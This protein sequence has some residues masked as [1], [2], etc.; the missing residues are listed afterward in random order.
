VAHC[1]ASA[2]RP[3]FEIADIVRAHRAELEKQYRLTL[4]QRRVLSAIELCRTAAL[5]GHLDVCRRCGFEQPAYNSCRNRHCPKCQALA[6]EKWIAARSE[7]VL[8]VGHFHVVFTLPSELRPLTRAFPKL[9]FEALFCAASETLLDLGQTRLGGVLGVTMVLHTW[10]RDLRF[11]PH[12]HAI[13]SAGVL[14]RAGVWQATSIK[15]LFPVEVLA[16]VFRGKMLDFLHRRHARLLFQ[17]YDPF[18]DPE[19]FDRLTARLAH[20]RWCVYAKRPFRRA[21][22]LLGY[23]GRYTHRVAIANSRLVELRPDAV[24]FRT[25]NGKTETL[26]PVQFLRRFVEHVLP[27]GFKKI[28]HFG[29]YATSHA[30]TLE[31]ARCQLSRPTSCATPASSWSERLLLLTGHDATHCP[32]CGDMLEHRPL[33]EHSARAPPQVTP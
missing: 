8:P 25:K 14:D 13:V 30:D 5:G 6:Q 27:A 11:H 15:Y 23:L 31:A 17:D 12:I 1:P 22:H 21:Q 7:R 33:I 18:Q 19:A 16:E 2:G 29:L 9:L 28:R 20:K 24:T 4:N 3:R 32:R 10:T 26:H